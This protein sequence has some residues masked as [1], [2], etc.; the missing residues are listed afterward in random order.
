MTLVVLVV[1]ANSSTKTVAEL[2]ALAKAAKPGLSHGSNGNGTAQH[3][4]GTPFENL[5]GAGLLHIPYEGSGPLT[6]DLPGGQGLKGFD[7][8]TWFDVL[9]PMATPKDI[10]ARH[11]GGMIRII[12]SLEFKKRMDEIGAEPVG[13]APEQMA[14]QI[15]DDTERFAALVRR[16]NV[17]IE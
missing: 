7:S 11:S 1:H 4:I 15:K 3:L 5:S 10:V 17:V 2:V 6:T 12:H 13:N 8:G 14:R 16:A 9:A